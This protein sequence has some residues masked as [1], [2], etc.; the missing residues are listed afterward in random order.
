MR[1]NSLI[2]RILRKVKTNNGKTALDELIQYLHNE[3]V[4]VK[5]IANMLEISSATVYKSL[6]V[7]KGKVMGRSKVDKKKGGAGCSNGGMS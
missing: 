7:R 3:G 5:E 1:I 6:K 4:L 2:I